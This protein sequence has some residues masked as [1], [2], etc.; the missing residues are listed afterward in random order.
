[1]IRVV[2]NVAT[3]SRYLR[4]Q[5]RLRS[6][7]AYFGAV[8]FSFW[9]GVEPPT[10][11]KH[12]DVP[13]AFKAYALKHAA[14]GT[15]LLL[16]CDASVVPIRSVEPLWERIER[17][18]YWMSDNGYSNYTWT[19]DSAYQDLFDT[20]L[21]AKNVELGFSRENGLTIG[22]KA[23]SVNGEPSSL[24]YF[25]GINRNIKHVVATTFG[26]NVR[27]PK[28]KAFLDEYYRLASET[29]AFCGPWWNKNSPED[30][31]KAG[32]Q[33]CGPPDV[34]GHRH[35]QTAASVI[36]WRLGFELTQPP[37]IVAYAPAQTESTI[38]LVDGKF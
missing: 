16:W 28:G 38:L 23:G 4:G 31:S 19:A 24:D 18:G 11:R 26:L 27:H 37:N 2:V 1:V 15:D 7:L 12:G 22:D 10:S 20:E 30:A 35:D 8:D 6:G 29:R 33:P 9:S 32:A 25:R 5:A 36:A 13:Y 21:Q 3:G 17:D 34:R 14:Y